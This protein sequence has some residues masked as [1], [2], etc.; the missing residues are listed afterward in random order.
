MKYE[1]RDWMNNLMFGGKEFDSYEEGW[2]FI[3]E[4]IEEE[5][6]GDGTYD[7]V[8]VLEKT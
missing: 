6:E 2:S 7:D 3:Y 5:Y 8:Y 4:N 1:I